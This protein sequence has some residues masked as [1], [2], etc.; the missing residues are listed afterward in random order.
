MKA[1][2]K[3]VPAIDKTF[4]ILELVAKSKEPLGISEITRAL[5]F[6]KSTVFNIIHTLTDL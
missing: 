5:D 3:R 4:A 1:S 6:N 2:F